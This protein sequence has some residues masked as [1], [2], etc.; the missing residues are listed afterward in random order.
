MNTQIAG[1]LAI[2]VVITIKF[3]AFGV[4]FANVSKTLDFHLPPEIQPLS[5]F[6]PNVA[7]GSFSDNGVALTL[8]LRHDPVENAGA[9]LAAN[10][11]PS[12]AVPSLPE[13]EPAA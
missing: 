7:L 8:S 5:G 11:A 12:P 3:R 1:I 9:P 2:V 10:S 13:Q 6:V 4:T